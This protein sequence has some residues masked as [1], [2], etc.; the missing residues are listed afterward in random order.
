MNVSV[1]VVLKQ[2]FHFRR[3]CSHLVVWFVVFVERL[4]VHV[5]V[6]N[7]VCTFTFSHVCD[8]VV[9]R[10]C[11]CVF[12]FT[13]VRGSCVSVCL[14]FVCLCV[15]RVHVVGVQIVCVVF[16]LCL[17]VFTLFV[18]VSVHVCMSCRQKNNTQCS[19]LA[20]RCFFFHVTCHSVVVPCL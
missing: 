1:L 15:I 3:A 10:G 19:S 2:R 12:S 16:K 14:C 20:A 9:V 7:R 5:C 18:C 17:C 11:V 4:C 6:G 8:V 13:S